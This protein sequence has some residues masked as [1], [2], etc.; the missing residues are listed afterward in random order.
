MADRILGMGD[1]INLAKKVEETISEEET[2]KMEKK[3]KKASFT[4]DDY[5]RQMNMIKKMGSIKGLMKMMPGF[6]SFGD[7]DFSENEIKKTEAII[8]S[9]TKK[10]R[11]EH[12]DID[13]SRRKRIANGSGTKIDD[14]NR[15][16][17]GFKR[18]KQ[19]LKKMPNLQKQGKGIIPNM[20]DIKQ[21]LGGTLWR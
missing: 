3:L 16:I 18:I 15:L 8:L 21:Q 9:M 10:E 17:K 5:L 19:L 13:Y 20:N 14:V 7:L 6:S 12:E 1:I 11:D 4:Y 2:R